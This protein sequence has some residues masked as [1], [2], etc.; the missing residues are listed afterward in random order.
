MMPTAFLHEIDGKGDIA[1]SHAIEKMVCS[2]G[3]DKHS[4]LRVRGR[5][6]GAVHAQVRVVSDGVRIDALGGER[7]VVNGKRTDGGKLQPGDIIDLG[8]VRL[9]FDMR[10]NEIAAV[11]RGGSAQT[12][13]LKAMLSATARFSEALAGSYQ[14]DDLI[15]TMLD[16]MIKVTDATRGAVLLLVEG[17]PRL[18]SAREAGGKQARGEF[19]ISDTIVAR[20]VATLQ[21]EI[22]SDAL[23]DTL[24]SAAESVLE[25]KLASVLCVPLL[26]R[27]EMLGVIYL[28]ND[29]VVN[30]FNNDALE[31]ATV[32]AAQA[33]MV[34]R[35]AILIRELQLTN[36]SLTQQLER[37]HFGS[38]I[39]TSGA[40]KEIFRKIDKV[41]KTDVSVLI[42]GETGTGKELVASELHRRS[43]RVD[44]P[45]IVINCGAIPENLLESELFGHVKGS[46]TGAINSR[47]GKFQSAHGGTLFLDEVGEM[48]LNLQVKLLRV[49]EDR[50]VTRIGDDKA[51]DVDIRVVAATNRTLTNE[52]KA[53]NFRED[54]FYRLNVVR[55][56]LP[57]LRERGSDVELLGRYF[58]KKHG[59]ELGVTLQGFGDDA[60]RSLRA[61]RWPGNIRELENRIKKAVIFCDDGIITAKDLD[62]QEVDAGGVQ[63]LNE[64]KESFALDYVRRIL[65]LN[66]GNRTQTA[67][68][69]GVD[70]RTIFR[71]LEK[72]R[73][74][75]GPE[76]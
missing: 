33:A 48:P 66:G 58:L 11:P 20:V 23:N 32:F 9:R 72:V 8:T 57:P 63:Q 60:M 41:A 34:L 24:F 68:E 14:I 27:G 64:A 7:L 17:K 54:L 44:G 51:R 28:G 42:E 65:E 71:Y 6:V 52:I 53:G 2:I 59:E 25:F 62:L 29:N 74:D 15:A 75:D 13:S 73:Q 45:F 10:L 3:T 18:R 56:E 69:L 70:V 22:V 47:D 31:V 50:R 36:E 19:Q 38:L 5:G 39:G 46:F 30:L 37:I 61:H 49:L 16:E 21:P 26:V 55:L 67:K 76:E 40:M 43:H 1:A 4:D 35:N 12:G